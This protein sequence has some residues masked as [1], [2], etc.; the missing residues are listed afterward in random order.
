MELQGP[1]G[2]CVEKKQDVSGMSTANQRKLPPTQ[3]VL[4]STK[5]IHTHRKM[6]GRGFL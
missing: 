6:V 1:L 2:P 4:L 3:H 5:H